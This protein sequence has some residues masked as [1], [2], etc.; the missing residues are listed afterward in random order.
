MPQK[1]IA[2]M[3]ESNVSLAGGGFTMPSGAEVFL[4][5]EVAL[6]YTC[7]DE[8]R[9]APPPNHFRLHTTRDSPPES[10]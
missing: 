10:N 8:N 5:H 4:F 7:K 2:F 3:S 1:N 6:G 9:R